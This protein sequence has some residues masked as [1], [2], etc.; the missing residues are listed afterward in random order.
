[1]I[2]Y[3]GINSPGNAPSGISVG[4]IRT[5]DTAARH[6][7]RIAAYSS[8]GPSW[9]DGYAKPDISA[10]GDNVLSIAAV[11]ST[12]RRAQEQ[13]GNIGNYMRLSGT[14]M[15]AAVASG[16]VAQVLQN[17]RGLTP[18]ALKMVLQYSSIPVKNEDGTYPNVLTQGA[19]GI[20]AGA[21]TLARA[22]NPS[23]PTGSNWLLASVTPSTFIGG[24][25]YAWSQRMVWGN[26]VARGADLIREQRPAWALAIVWGDGLEDDDNI[27]WGNYADDDNIVWGNALDQDD[28]IVWGFNVVWA[29]S[30]E[31]DDN[32]VWGNIDDDNIVWGNFDDDDIVW[33]NQIV[34]GNSLI[35]ISLDDDNIVWGNRDDDNIVWGNLDDD[36][37]VWGNLDDDNIV[38]GNSDDDNIVWGNRDDDNIVWGNRDDDNIV[39]GN[40]A[41][42]GTI[43]QTAPNRG[44]AI[45]GVNAS[46]N[47][48]GVR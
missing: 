17:N 2:G 18:N 37:I 42:L 21:V 27:V 35:G 1:V 26:H 44:L 13:R 19:G 48:T 3:G 45:A 14:S 5:F 36:N 24:Q 4:S 9:I 40:R 28:N 38:W 43:I 20:N 23:A 11:G 47:A 22:I 8:R 12:L 41:L 10:P 32:I 25:S 39:W 16:M 33:G 29:N 7:D 30:Q 34:W 46:A 6:D 15:A 31:D